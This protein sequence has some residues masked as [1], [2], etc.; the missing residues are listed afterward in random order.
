MT[1]SHWL[2]LALLD[3]GFL[4]GATGEVGNNQDKVW[5]AGPVE[6]S[7]DVTDCLSFLPQVR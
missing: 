1:V 7:G 2:W 4:T 3:F 6:R 5:R